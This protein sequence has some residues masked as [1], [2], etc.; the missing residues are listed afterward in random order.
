MENKEHGG[1]NQEYTDE[2]GCG[3][4]IINLNG[5]VKIGAIKK[6]AFKQT[7]ERGEK[8][9]AFISWGKS[10]AGGGISQCKAPKVGI[11][12]VCA[13]DWMSVSS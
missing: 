7:L 6:L 11:L 5:L 2:G 13:T 4:W 8:E 12:L 10:V 1:R 3:K 9:M